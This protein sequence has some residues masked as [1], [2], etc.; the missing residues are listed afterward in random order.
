[1]ISCSSSTASSHPATSAKVT[2]GSSLP[3]CLARDLP[4]CITPRPRLDMF[5]T[6]ERADQQHGGQQ[7]HQQAGP[8]GVAL[9]VG[10]DLDGG[11]GGVELVDQLVG[12]LGRV[13]DLVLG[14]V[15]ELADHDV[16]VVLDLRGGIALVD[17]L[18][19]G[20]EVDLVAVGNPGWRT[21]CRRTARRL[22][23]AGR[24]GRRG[25]RL[26]VAIRLSARHAA[27][28][29]AEPMNSQT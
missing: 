3:T 10:R 28:N 11:V 15:P 27:R 23:R 25:M 21:G 20:G 4:N 7:A 14:V 2:V 17:G 16:V 6:R 29:Q 22:R 26:T 18:A 1:M 9:L 24:S 8:G 12:E 5:M 13:G 19:E